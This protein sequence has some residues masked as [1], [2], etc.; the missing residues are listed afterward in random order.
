MVKIAVSG[1][2]GTGK[3]TLCEFL[4]RTKG[5]DLDLAI[6]REVPRIIID[7]VG[8]QSFFKRGNNTVERQLLIFLYQLEEERKKGSGKKVLL[9]DRTPIDHLAYTLAN[10]PE[11]RGSPE[12]AALNGLIE[13]WLKTFD[14]IFKVPIEFALHDDGIREGEA[15]FQTEINAAIDDLYSEFQVSTIEVSGSVEDRAEQIAGAIR[16][17]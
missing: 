12:H 8:E 2:H 16:R 9:C 1:A 4:E 5:A 17:F 15:D 11:F 7:R 14:L 13:D 6:C 3:T 10:H